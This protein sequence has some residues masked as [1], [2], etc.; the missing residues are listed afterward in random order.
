MPV[1]IRKAGTNKKSHAQSA[2]EPISIQ[3]FTLGRLRIVSAC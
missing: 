3:F 2:F 1:M